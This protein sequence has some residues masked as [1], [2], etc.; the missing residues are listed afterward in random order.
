MLLYEF[1]RLLSSSSSVLPGSSI[2]M[3]PTGS[4]TVYPE[5][6]DLFTYTILYALLHPCANRAPLFPAVPETLAFLS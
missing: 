3:T 5:S 4:P 1:P 2:V 6:T